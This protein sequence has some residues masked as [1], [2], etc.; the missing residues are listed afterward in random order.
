VY[1]AAV[2]HGE[3]QQPVAP[4]AGEHAARA[5]TDAALGDARRAEPEP[6]ADAAAVAADAAP[7]GRRAARRRR[8][9]VVRDRAEGRTRAFGATVGVV[10]RSR[11]RRVRN[12]AMRLTSRLRATQ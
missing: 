9:L 10:T 8:P 5:R 4:R 7:R 11:R 3:V 2:P 6:D 12:A 1:R